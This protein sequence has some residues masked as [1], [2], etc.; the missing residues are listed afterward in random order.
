[1]PDWPPTG[2]DSSSHGLTH[3]PELE[4]IVHKIL[5]SLTAP[6]S[7]GGS[8]LAAAPAADAA[9][10]T[11][12]TAPRAVAGYVG[13]P[14]ASPKLDTRCLGKRG[15]LICINQS[16][17]RL[18]FLRDGKVV[19]DF[20]VRT[21]RAGMRT[22]TGVFRVEWKDRNSWSNLYHVTM[23][24]SRYHP[25][26]RPCATRPTSPRPATAS[27]PTAARTCATTPEPA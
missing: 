26:D 25:A 9:T 12:P 11:A 20:S 15:P 1:M 14:Q 6:A 8:L 2:S 24:F 5:V 27:A 13:H 22:R 23:P 10:R 4:V 19:D 18:Y 3:T 21:G 7:V 16:A 17:N